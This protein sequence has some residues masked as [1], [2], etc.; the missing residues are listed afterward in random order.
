MKRAIAASALAALMSLGVASAYAQP[1]GMTQSEHEAHHPDGG[2]DQ[3]AKGTGMM[4]QGMMSGSGM[5]GAGMMQGMM[6]QGGMRG[7]AHG[8]MGPG[9]TKMMVIMMDTDGNGT[10]SLDE[11]QAV[12]ARMFKAMDANG[13]GQLSADEMSSFCSGGA[14]QST[15]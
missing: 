6:G 11:V 8:M 7:G 13:D 9:M 4:G 10:L 14:A 1:A 3:Q 12:H 5:M 2:A 15:D